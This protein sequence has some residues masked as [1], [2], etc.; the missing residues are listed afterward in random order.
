MNKKIVILTF[1][2][3]FLTQSF[4]QVKVTNNDKCYIYC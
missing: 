3:A 4:V 1:F 2:S